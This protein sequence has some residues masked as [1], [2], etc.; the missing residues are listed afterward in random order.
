MEMND[1][2]E[3]ESHSHQSDEQR[4]GWPLTRR[5]VMWLLWSDALTIISSFK[6]KENM[7]G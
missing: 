4:Q 3:A 6:D 7:S 5:L 1:D 2:A